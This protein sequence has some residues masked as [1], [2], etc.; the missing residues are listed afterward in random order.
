LIGDF[1]T[2]EEAAAAYNQRA[3]EIFGEFARLNVV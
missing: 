3:K 2:Q 1:R